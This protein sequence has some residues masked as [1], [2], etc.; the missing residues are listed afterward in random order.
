MKTCLN[1]FVA[2]L[3][4]VA[5]SLVG[6]QAK[7]NLTGTWKMNP[8]KTE[9]GPNGGPDAI[10]MEFDQKE[11]GLTEKLTLVGGGGE[12][13]MN[14]K[15]TTDGKDGTNEIN[16]NPVTTVAR[17][18]GEALVIEWKGEGV[19]FSRK[20]TLSA[21]GKMMTIAVRQTGPGGEITQTVVLDKQ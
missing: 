21:D 20:I 12:R 5:V 3:M 9:F 6:A 11:T 1:V 15:Y 8:Q 17:W 14:L 19:T 13:T 16:G 2:V 10:T 18:D 4:L 7:P